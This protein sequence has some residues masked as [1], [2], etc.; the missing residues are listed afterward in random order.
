MPLSLNEDTVE[1][2]PLLDLSDQAA[3]PHTEAYQESQTAKLHLALG[4]QSPG[5]EGLANSMTTS[6]ADSYKRILADRDHMQKLQT[7]NDVLDSILQADPSTITPE[8]VDVVQG[9]S[10]QQLSAPDR[11]DIIERE[12]AKKFV[13]VGVSTMENDIVEDSM[14]ADPEKTYEMMDRAESFAYKSNYLNTILDQAQKSVDDQSWLGT[15]YNLGEN[16]ILGN[17]QTYNQVDLDNMSVLPGKNRLEGYAFLWSLQNP[18]EFK[19]YMDNIKADLESRNPYAFRDW[20]QGMVSF[21]NEDAALNTITAGM[22][23]ASLVPVGKLGTALKGLSK[24][25][26]M[27]PAKLSEIAGVVG[28]NLDSGIGRVAEDVADGSLLGGIKNAKDLEKTVPNLMSPD[29]AMVGGSQLSK[30]SYNRLTEALLGQQDLVRRVLSTNTIDR[31]TP[32]EVVS[33][34]DD[35]ASRFMKDNPQIGKNV[36]SVEAPDTPDIGN[37]YNAKVI[38]GQRDGSLFE[39]EKQAQNYV[40]RN[41]KFKQSDYQIVQK[42]DGYQVEINKTLDEDRLYDLK[43][44]TN[45]QT[46]QSLSDFSRTLSSARSPVELLSPQQNVARSVLTTSKEKIDELFSEMVKPIGELSKKE[47][48]ELDDLLFINQKGQKFYDNIGE[49]DQAFY[50]RWKKT[51]TDKQ[52]E[53]YFTYTNVSDLDLVVRDLDWYKQKAAKGFEDIDLDL[54]VDRTPETTEHWKQSFE[55]RVIDNLPYTDPTPFKV[56]IIQDGQL[57]TVKFSATM[58]QAGRDSIAKLQSEG[59]K[60][61]NAVDSNFNIDGKYL[62]YV[63]AKNFRRSRVGVK[64]VD[65]KAGGHKVVRDPYYIKQGRVAGDDDYKLYR[66]DQTFFNARTEKEANDFAKVLEEARQKLLSK[67]PDAAK[68]VRDNLP[69]PVREFMAGVADGSI[70]LTHPFVVTRSGQRAID[71]SAYKALDLKDMTR[72]SHKPADQITG[73]FAGERSEAD[74]SAIRSEGDTRWKIEGAPYLSPLEAMKSASSDMISA[75]LFNDYKIMT[76]KN[77]IREFS[78]VL[79]GSPSELKAQGLDVVQNP[80][81]LQSAERSPELSRKVQQARNV[82]RSFNTLMDN[83]DAFSRNVE[84]FKEKLLSPIIPK[85]GPRG[86]EWTTE[87]M[88]SRSKNP[89]A[90][91]KSLAFHTKMGFWNPTQYFKQANAAVNIVSVGGL[92]GMKSVGVYPLL[93]GAVMTNKAENLARL[94]E[95]AQ[96]VGVMSKDDFLE[97][98]SLYKKSGFNDIGGDTAYLDDLRSPEFVESKF[99]KTTKGVMKTSATPFYEGERMSRL[100][101]WNTAYLDKKAALKGKSLTR[102][103][104]ADILYRAKTL[105]GNMTREANAPWQKGYVSVITQFFGYQARIM[106]QMLG[107]Q[108]TAGEKARLFTAYSMMY[109]VP[110]GLA[111]ATG[112]LPIRDIVVQQMYEQGMDPQNP[113]AKPFIDGFVSAFTDYA[114]GKDWNISSSYGPGGLPTFYDMFRGDKTFADLLLGA[115][116]GIGADSMSAMLSGSWKGLKAILSETD[117]F[118]GGLYN[119]AADDFVKALR[120]ITTVDSMYKMYHVYNAGTWMSKNGYDIAKMDMPDAVFAAITG[121]QPASVEQAFS[122]KSA[123]KSLKEGRTQAMFDLTKR[124]KDARRM[125]SGETREQVIRQIK[126]EMEL[127]GFNGHEKMQIN[128]RAWDSKTLEDISL[129]QFEK[130]MKRKSPDE[131]GEGE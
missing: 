38:V 46:P 26:A 36:I 89:A 12:Y 72:S 75:R 94:G 52:R 96:K 88:L 113:A 122:K 59:Y 44:D 127:W 25:S 54:H 70:D 114:F 99:K 42:G 130:E 17:Y 125:E 92:N 5:L 80:K 32:E 105:I 126:T 39:S 56:G 50:D 118:D 87:T 51:P 111:S 11:S 119:L 21:G 37:V 7:Q 41:I 29:K 31:L 124:L 95:I 128:K 4:D 116:G 98:M 57:K 58:G 22:D 103:D 55:G 40:N 48:N 3:P 34:R 64:N 65:R 108:L 13:N 117:D 23:L 78:D 100:A 74:I 86:Q 33:L 14:N 120:N 121:L 68:F 102:R 107:K 112:V 67:S 131:Q 10:S 69:I 85:L 30:A 79:D 110:V 18:D 16:M 20:F 27:N 15:V 106:D 63:V 8:V 45:Q 28:K 9:L 129:D 84:L 77:F 115:S 24:A 101:A 90:W 49:F 60:I 19:N 53:A 61:I 62:D 104:E 1:R 6:G 93:R 97:S 123:A 109:G 76:M 66:G 83:S 71:T 73:R 82:S 2:K 47:L 35:L 43:L 81:F 91:L